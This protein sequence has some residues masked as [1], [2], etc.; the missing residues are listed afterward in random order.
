MFSGLTAKTQLGINKELEFSEC[1]LGSGAALSLGGPGIFPS[2]S[3][4][5]CF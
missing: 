3:Y 1:L 4:R 5:Y 2:K